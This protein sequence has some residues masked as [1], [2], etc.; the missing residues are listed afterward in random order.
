MDE[1]CRPLVLCYGNRLRADDGVAWH[2]ADRLAGDRRL[3]GVEV[4][5]RHQLA[6]ELAEDV[7]RAAR[8][9]IVDAAAR[10]RPGSVERSTP[11]AAVGDGPVP[12]LSHAVTPAALG[13]LARA[14]YGRL[15]PIDVLTVS[16]SDFGA[17]EHLSEAVA[18][19]VAEAAD[20]VAAIVAPTT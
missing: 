5:C 9:V 14:L 8:V 13:A 12:A 1:G 2:V 19:A 17:G 4:L 11:A 6:P 20:A 18:S 10:G 16:G 15:P 3:A 7:S